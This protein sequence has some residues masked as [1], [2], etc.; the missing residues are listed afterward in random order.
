VVLPP[1]A[2]SILPRPSFFLVVSRVKTAIF[3][4]YHCHCLAS[5]Y[6]RRRLIALDVALFVSL[7]LDQ[8]V[9]ALRRD[10]Y[11]PLASKG[12]RNAI[13]WTLFPERMPRHDR[14]RL[15]P[16]SKV[17][18]L[19]SSVSRTCGPFHIQAQRSEQFLCTILL[20][21]GVNFFF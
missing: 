13:V 16:G 17:L 14:S 5:T 19:V 8:I 9:H 12:G 18:I 3:F 10:A 11:R 6:T 15:Q 20:S 21:S 7:S 1:S 2:L 4:V